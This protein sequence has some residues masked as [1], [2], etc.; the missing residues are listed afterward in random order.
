MDIPQ[1]ICFERLRSTPGVLKKILHNSLLD[2]SVNL[3]E[4][5]QELQRV[6]ILL[7]FQ[8]DMFQKQQEADH[9]GTP[10]RISHNSL[11]DMS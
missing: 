2:M 8:S 4:V 3:H 7:I 9:E 11:L 5:D 10:K 6:Y 1:E